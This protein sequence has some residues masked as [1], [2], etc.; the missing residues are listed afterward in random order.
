MTRC[1]ALLVLPS[2]PRSDAEKGDLQ[3]GAQLLT[4]S[5]EDLRMAERVQRALRA[6][7]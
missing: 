1:A 7:G 4:Q 6:T 3:T 2:R 5:V